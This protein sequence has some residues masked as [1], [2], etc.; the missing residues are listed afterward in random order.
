MSKPKISIVIPVYNAEKTIGNILEKLINQSY[1]NIE[2]IVVDDGSLDGSLG[3]LYDLEGRDPRIIVVSQVNAG[4][5][6]ARNAGIRKST[7][8][9]VTFI[10]SDDDVSVNIISELAGYATANIDTDFVM[11][12]MIMG[13]QNISAPDAVVEGEGN[14]ISYTLNSLLTKNLMYGPC[15]KLFR[16]EIV[17][18]NK[19]EFPVDVKYGEDTIFVLSYLSKVKKIQITSKLLYTY[20]ITS[21]GL[22]AT[23]NSVLEYRKARLRALKAFKK[24]VPLAP[25]VRITYYLLRMRWAV[26]YAKA[27]LGAIL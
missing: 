6:A 26:A 14:I 13:G 19:L 10:D 11:C 16:R 8:D 20:Q 15:C 9:F 21:D 23:S 27:R 17:V 4:A 22:S 3:I 24:N 1:S 7:G 12:G 2:I 5:S 25:E 18:N